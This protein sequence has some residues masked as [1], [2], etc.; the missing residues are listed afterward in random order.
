MAKAFSFK[1]KFLIVGVV[2]LKANGMLLFLESDNA[3][4]LGVEL[5]DGKLHIRYRIDFLRGQTVAQ[6]I[7]VFND[8]KWH[9]L[10]VVFEKKIFV[11]STY[12]ITVTSKKCMTLR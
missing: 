7:P 12:F 6:N 4:F 2:F 1:I 10:K 11:C 8:T 3:D 5:I 9:N